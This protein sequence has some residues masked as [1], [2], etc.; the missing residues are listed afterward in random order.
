MALHCF[1]GVDSNCAFKG[2]GKVGPLKKLLKKPKFMDTFRDLGTNWE[3]TSKTMLQLEEFVCFM[4]GH[5]KTKSLDQAR[6]I[7]LHK[8]TGGNNGSLKHVKKVDLAKLPPCKR[9]LIPHIKRV[10]YRVCQWKNSHISSP[11]IPPPSLQHGWNPSDTFLEPVWSE[12]PVLPLHLTDIIQS[13]PFSDGLS[14]ESDDDD[15]DI[16]ST[17]ESCSD[18][19]EPDSDID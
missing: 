8:A 7:M 3:V 19:S 9:S 17:D 16:V 2:K 15:D 6:F 1:T 4:Y 12:G 10:N 14:V 18:S 11:A 13:T 5:S